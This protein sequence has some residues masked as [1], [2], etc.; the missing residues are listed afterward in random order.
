MLSPSDQARVGM[1]LEPLHSTS[2][3]L[4]R[5][6]GSLRVLKGFSSRSRTLHTISCKT[7]AA[8][9][10][11]ASWAREEVIVNVTCVFT[12]FALYS[13][14]GSARHLYLRQ[15]VPAFMLP[16]TFTQGQISHGLFMKACSSNF[17][18]VSAPGPVYHTWARQNM[19]RYRS[20]LSYNAMLIFWTASHVADGSV[21]LRS[22]AGGLYGDIY[23]VSS[24]L[25]PR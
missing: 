10:R 3:T 6:D 12:G 11:L 7:C 14:Y 18:P 2:W 4:L 22:S 8:R 20:T 13:T 5:L 9:R 25:R 1:R 23:H 21:H 17:A 24:S 19:S 16:S 15:P